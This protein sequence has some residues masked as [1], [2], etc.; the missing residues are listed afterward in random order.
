MVSYFVSKAKNMNIVYREITSV[1]WKKSPQLFTCHE[2]GNTTNTQPLSLIPYQSF[3]ELP[4]D[5]FYGTGLEL[6]SLHH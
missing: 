3:S 6:V 2:E 5:Q 4:N 1:K